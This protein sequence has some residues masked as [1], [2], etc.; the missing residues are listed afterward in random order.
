VSDEH[1]PVETRSILAGM[2]AD[3]ERRS[4][5]LNLLIGAAMKGDHEVRLVVG[6]W[7]ETLL[8]TPTEGLAALK[9]AGVRVR[10]TLMERA[11]ALDAHVLKMLDAEQ[12]EAL[13]VAQS[14][15][16][17]AAHLQAALFG[18]GLLRWTGE[19]PRP[20]PLGLRVWALHAAS[21]SQPRRPG[22][23]RHPR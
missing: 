18:S 8:L 23:N 9:L 13:A 1:D 2:V 21:T 20:S 5:T 3:S 12:C 6:G 14:G 11:A 16:E 22:R 17:V 15:G 19:G 4:A 10:R 7:E